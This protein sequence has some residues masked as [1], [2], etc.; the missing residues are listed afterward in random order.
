[1]YDRS[2]LP[3][4]ETPSKRGQIEKVCR[5]APLGFG[6]VYACRASANDPAE[7]GVLSFP[8]FRLDPGDERLWRDDREIPLRRKP[9]AILRFLAENPQLLVTQRELVEAVWGKVAMSESL[10]RTHIHE[11]RQNVGE[12]VVETVVGRGY[13]FI[14]KVAQVA[15]LPAA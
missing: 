12:G 1:A 15:E 4:V 6:L 3:A 8:P 5:S 2:H 14:P 7:K 11:L 13:R 10:L 9:F